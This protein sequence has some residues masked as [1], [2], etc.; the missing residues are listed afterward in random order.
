MPTVFF[1]SSV[2]PD[3]KEYWTQ[4]FTRSGNNVLLGILS[5][6]PQNGII[7]LSSLPIPSFP[8]G[9][10]FIRGTKEVVENG[11]TINLLPFINIMF[12]KDLCK[13]LMT[14]YYLWKWRKNNKSEV[15]KVLVYNIYTPPIFILYNVCK[16]LNIELYAM[17]YDLG[18]PPKRLKLSLPTM[19]G[20]KV[21]EFFAKRYIPKLDGRIVINESIIN[22]YA[23]GRDFILIDGGINAVIEEGLFHLDVSTEETYTFVCAGMLWDQN[24]TK[25]ILQAMELNKQPNIRVIFAG[26]G[27]DVPLIQEAEKSDKRIKYLG[28]LTIDELMEVY[29]QSDVLLNLRIEEEEDFHFPSKLLE[30]M[31]I[32]RLVLSTNI[33]HAQRDYGD[34]IMFLNAVTPEELAKKMSEITLMSKVELYEYGVRSRKFMLDN[35][36]WKTRTKEILNYM[37]MTHNN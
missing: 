1:I 22:H 30:Y 36:T 16:W 3:K 34:I 23:P 13:G 7:T 37:K 2:V 8:Y 27:N 32:G 24:G 9:P 6:L 29:K 25:L 31:A 35:R 15:C 14:A 5:S 26:K 10:L 33:A 11:K 20:Y 18:V 19:L 21:S 4:A 28:M 12:I 17:L